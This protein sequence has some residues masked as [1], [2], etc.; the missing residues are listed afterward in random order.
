MHN[1]PHHGVAGF[2]VEFNFRWPPPL[3]CMRWLFGALVPRVGPELR[4]YVVVME[5]SIAER[6]QFIEPLVAF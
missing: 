1:A 4:W 3:P 2:D 5:V 6:R